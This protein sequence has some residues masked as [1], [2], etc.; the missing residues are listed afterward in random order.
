MT[1][2]N[3]ERKEEIMSA[4]KAKADLYGIAY[5]PNIGEA[6]LRER[7]E[8]YESKQ[9]K[10]ESENGKKENWKL[11]PARRLI[12]VRISNLDVTERDLPS[13]YRG[14]VT[15][16]FTEAR[17][18]PLDTEWWVPECIVKELE[19]DMMQIHVDQVDEKT[20]RKTGNKIPKNVKK[21][22]IQY[23]SDTPDEEIVSKVKKVEV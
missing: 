17:V 1:E 23:I 6:K 8:E 15:K 16:H 21:Y 2:N 22:N 9:P 10:D 3:Q 12:K 11:H 19:N 4:L 5:S 7:I 14:V 18:I 13:I 20:G